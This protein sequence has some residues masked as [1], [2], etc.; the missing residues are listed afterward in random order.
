MATRACLV[1]NN[2]DYLQSLPN[3]VE[4][5]FVAGCVLDVLITARDLGHQGWILANHPLYG[6]FTPH[7]QPYRSLLMLPPVKDANSRVDGDYFSSLGFLEEALNIYQ[8]PKRKCRPE[9]MPEHMRRD[10]ALIDR[11]LMK[12]TLASLS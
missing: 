3:N 2:P 8:G 5:R 12:S 1:S 10:C 9:D 4:L 6:N 11:E 7:Q